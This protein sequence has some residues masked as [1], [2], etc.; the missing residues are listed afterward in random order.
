[1]ALHFVQ[2][3]YRRMP[4]LTAFSIYTNNYTLD[5]SLKTIKH[6]NVLPFMKRIPFCDM[7]YVPISFPF[8]QL[9]YTSVLNLGNT[10]TVMGTL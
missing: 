4:L 6:T 2:Y 8:T 1:M 5:P 10:R 3:F 7:L 9:C